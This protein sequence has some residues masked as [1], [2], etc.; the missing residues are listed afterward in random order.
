M[1]GCRQMTQLEPVSTDADAVESPDEIETAADAREYCANA[2]E[3]TMKQGGESFVRYQ[4]ENRVPSRFKDAV[5]DIDDVI[6]LHYHVHID[7]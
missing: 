2:D 7:K 1:V 3:F 6:A 4:C 5:A